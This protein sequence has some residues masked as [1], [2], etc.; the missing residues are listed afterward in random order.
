MEFLFNTVLEVKKLK[1]KFNV[2]YILIIRKLKV[3]VDNLMYY[4]Y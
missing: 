2:L 4:T 3:L 1:V